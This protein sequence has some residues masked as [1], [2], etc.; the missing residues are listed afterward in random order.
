MSLVSDKYERFPYVI[1]YHSVSDRQLP[2]FKYIIPMKSSK[3][4]EADLDYLSKH[5]EFISIAQFLSLRK[6]GNDP[7]KRKIILTFDDGYSEVSDIVQ[8]ILLRKGIPAAIF[9]TGKFLDDQDMYYRC[10][11]SVLQDNIN[12]SPTS[13]ETVLRLL[14]SFDKK[15]QSKYDIFHVLQTLRHHELP[16]INKIAEEIGIDFR[17][18]LDQ[19]KPYLSTRQVEILLTNGFEIGAHSMDHPFFGKISLQEQIQQT[20]ASMDMMQ[21][22]FK[23]PYRYFAIPHS[24]VGISADYFLQE[25][26]VLDIILGGYGLH[27]FPQYQYYQRFS[28]EKYRCA[29]PFA[30]K[31]ETLKVNLKKTFEHSHVL[32]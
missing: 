1:Y 15:V 10:K 18:Y 22:L 3:Q 19:Y 8:P 16:L 24:D 28:I 27:R 7:G 12:K 4:L 6:I 26:K 13:F 2:H 11:V 25:S 23:L 32:G 14:K 20:S 5:Y 17:S 21:K 9:I 31:M 30:W 29:T